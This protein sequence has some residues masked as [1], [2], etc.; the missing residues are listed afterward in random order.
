MGWISELLGP[1]DSLP[2][3]LDL[4]AIFHISV[5]IL[6]SVFSLL[7]RLTYTVIFVQFFRLLLR[8]RCTNLG[9][10]QIFSL[11]G[12]WRVLA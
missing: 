7:L 8:L 10:F 12:F 6:D 3:L 1:L 2:C 11:E 5:S 9:N 4:V